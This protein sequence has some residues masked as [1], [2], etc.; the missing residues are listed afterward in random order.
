MMP[1]EKT[2]KTPSRSLATAIGRGLVPAPAVTQLAAYMEREGHDVSII[3]CN[4]LADPWADL[5][6]EIERL[7][8]GV[9]GISN[10]STSY[11]N[12]ALNAAL[13][14]KRARRR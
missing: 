5:E 8:P 3:D 11:V 7:A 6:R 1:K 14:I 4:T 13:L 2:R 9:V 10:K 12:E